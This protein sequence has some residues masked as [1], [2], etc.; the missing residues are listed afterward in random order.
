MKTLETSKLYAD[1]K[2]EQQS[3]PDTAADWL[4]VNLGYLQICYMLHTLVKSVEQVK[5][6]QQPLQ[7]VASS[8][9]DVVGQLCRHTGGTRRLWSPH[10]GLQSSRSGVMFSC[11]PV[12]LFDVQLTCRNFAPHFG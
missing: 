7:V 12:K 9:S 2:N 11:C 8:S 3:C 5:Q 10:C 6:S 1:L 4:R